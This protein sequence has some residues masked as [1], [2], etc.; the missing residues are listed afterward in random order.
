MEIKDVKKKEKRN[1]EDSHLPGKYCVPS[2]PWFSLPTDRDVGKEKRY[3]D[4]NSKSV[5]YLRGKRKRSQKRRRIY[6][7]SRRITRIMYLGG[8]WNRKF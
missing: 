6:Q 5:H 2:T 1:A 8:S 7:R 3:Q 4:T